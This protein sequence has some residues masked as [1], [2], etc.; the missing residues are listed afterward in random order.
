MVA[1]TALSIIACM[2]ESLAAFSGC[3]WLYRAA[4]RV[5]KWLLN[6]ADGF[7]VLTEKARE[8]LFP[9]TVEAETPTAEAAA[10]FPRKAGSVDKRGRPIEV[11]PCC[12]DIERFAIVDDNLRDE[13][14]GELGCR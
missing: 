4:K 14:R 6:E 10:L 11:I 13:I 8:I 2:K 12:V 3:G 5:E 1:R 9:E 7:V